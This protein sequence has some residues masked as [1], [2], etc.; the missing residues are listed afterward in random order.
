MRFIPLLF[1]VMLLTVSCK[2]KKD[3]PCFKKAGTSNCSELF[4]AIQQN[5]GEQEKILDLRDCYDK[6]CQ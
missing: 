5:L 1:T 4:E 2:S 3:V 6:H